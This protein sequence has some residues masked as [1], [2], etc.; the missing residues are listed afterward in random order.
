MHSLADFASGKM[1]LTANRLQP[2]GRVLELRNGKNVER[3]RAF[4]RSRDDGDCPVHGLVPRAAKNVAKERERA[5]LVGHQ[6]YLGDL[7]R[8]NVRTD[9]EI[10]HVE[11]HEDVGRG[12][13]QHDRDALLER[14]LIRG[15]GEF[16]G[17][18][19]DHLL[20]GLRR[21]TQTNRTGP[22]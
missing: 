17:Q 21:R 22:E 16:P 3:D 11:A 12:E 4:L 14:K 9:V 8:D 10:R 19:L 18:Y 1:Q 2:G 7:T 20:L 6:A 15:V 5:Y 13:L